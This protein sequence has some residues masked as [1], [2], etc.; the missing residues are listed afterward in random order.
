[1]NRINDYIAVF[2]SGVGGVSVLRQLLKIMPEERYLYFGDSAN[3]PYGTR[4]AEEV[5][6]LT[7]AA[8][9]RFME[10][11]IKALV[12]A[13]NTAT[14]AAIG[15]LRQKYPDTI[16]IGIEPAL[17]MAVNR[18]PSG[19]VGVLAT[20]VTLAGEKFSQLFHRF[21]TDCEIIPIPAPGLA[22]L[23]EAGKANSPQ[24]RQLLEPLLAPYAGKLDALVLGCT[25]YPFAEQTISDIL[26]ERVALL[27]GGEGTARET[28]RRLENAGL[29]RSGKGK[30]IVENSIGSAQMLALTMDL[31][32]Q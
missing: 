8:A 25:H 4:P 5:R 13:C 9:A 19:Q 6:S 12:V 26:G 11:G 1:M 20:P 31:I 17:K 22:E 16:I 30:V 18:Y 14:A 29:L 10:R 2:D 27:D 7:M 23:V 28:R 21:E 32:E 15:E 3:A 24:S